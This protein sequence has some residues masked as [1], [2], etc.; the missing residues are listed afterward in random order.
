MKALLK[1]YSNFTLIVCFE[2]QYAPTLA[3]LDEQLSYILQSPEHVI[4]NFATI[5]SLET[6]EIEML[7]FFENE[8]SSK[9]KSLQYIYFSDKLKENS[10][11][12]KSF[13]LRASFSDALNALSN[14]TICKKMGTQI[15]FVK[16]FVDATIRVLFIQGK[17][18]SKRGKIDFKLE[19]KDH[20]I[21]PISGIIKVASSEFPYDIV[22]SFTEECYLSLI[23]NMLGEKQIE[24]TNE[25]KDGATEILNIIYGQAKLVL[26]QQNA[27]IEPQIPV[28]F[29]G[30]QYQNDERNIFKIPFQT[31]NGPFCIEVRVPKG[32]DTKNFFKS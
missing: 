9:M 31:E 30:T 2:D 4:I 20:L 12:A 21:G 28:L 32:A 11:L 25:N 13:V 22:I 8:L 3:S 1:K 26:N 10:P 16:A 23:S 5:K 18:L 17:A 27:V 24:I 7:V 14:N 29:L 15:H 6:K 19:N